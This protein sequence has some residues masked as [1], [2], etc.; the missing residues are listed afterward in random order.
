MHSLVTPT[1]S[2]IHLTDPLNRDRPGIRCRCRNRSR[3][4]TEHEH[5]MIAEKCPPG[6]CLGRGCVGNASGARQLA[7]DSL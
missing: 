3:T 2:R 5:E 4:A 7:E 6:V 1:L